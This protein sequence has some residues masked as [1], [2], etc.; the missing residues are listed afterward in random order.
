MTALLFRIALA[1]ADTLRN[2][3]LS[4]AHGMPAWGWIFPVLLTMF[5]AGVSVAITRRYAPEASG[6]GIPHLKAVL[7]RF[8][9]LDWKRVLPVKFFGGILAIGSGL[10]LGREGPTVQMGGAVGDAISRWLKTSKHERLT[11]ISAGAGAGLAAAFNAPLSGLIFVL[12]EVRRDF[13][14]IVFGAAFLASAVAAIVAQIGSG[15]FPV[16]A[17]PDYPTPP[18]TALPIFAALGVIAALFGTLFNRILLASLDIY[19][20]I[21]AQRIVPVAAIVGGCIGLIGWFHPLV[22]GSGHALAES[23]LR[24]ELLLAAVPVFFAIRALL[25]PM[26]YG[27]GAPG[28]IFAPLLVLGAL[29]GLGIGQAAHLLFPEAAPI[30]AVFAVVGMAAY[31]TAIVRAPLTGIMLIVEMTGNYS[32]MLPLLVSCFCAYAVTE[33][34]KDLPIYEALLQRDLKR[35]GEARLLRVPVVMEFV[36]QPGAP[37]AG[38]EV[39]SLGLPS[40]CLLVRCA[41]GTREWVPKADTRLE[42]HTRITAMIA[43]EA[44]H[45]LTLLQHGCLASIARERKR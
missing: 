7:L 11:L 24:G 31:F 4:W 1:G 25:T 22:T 3:L 29:L 43:P 42:A 30:P 5:G 33:L 13:Q 27:T 2:R 20:R 8:R 19:A 38:R 16:F 40:G 45:A 36:I 12:E 39:R 32:Q 35:R 26:S 21:P 18:L 34:L 37:F 23:A 28:G 14:P 15:Q 41:N 9:S 10:V 17:V 6:S 44:S